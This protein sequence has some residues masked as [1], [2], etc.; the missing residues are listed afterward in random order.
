MRDAAPLFRRL[1]PAAVAVSVFAALAH[2]GLVAI[3]ARSIGL[4]LVYIAALSFLVALFV[5]LPGGA[6]LL[7]V[8]AILKLKPL[9]SLVLFVA[10]IQM[11]AIALEISLF[12]GGLDDI[13]WQYGLISIPAALIAWYSSVYSASRQ[14]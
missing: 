8:V 3:A 4:E 10:A 13:S 14:G 6:V 11:V 7:A 9:A 12:E 5:A 1:F 2:A